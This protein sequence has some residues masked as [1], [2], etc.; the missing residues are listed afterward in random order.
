MSNHD[1][2]IY[3]DDKDDNDDNNNLKYDRKNNTKDYNNKELRK[4]KRIFFGI[5]ATIR[6]PQDV[7][8][9][10]VCRMFLYR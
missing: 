4:N 8:W 3:D 10:P 5:I 2:D 1:D 9:S 6:A 7:E